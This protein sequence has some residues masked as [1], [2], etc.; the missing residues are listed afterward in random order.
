[1]IARERL[2]SDFCEGTCMVTNHVHELA[3][4]L[5][6]LPFPPEFKSLAGK[7]GNWEEGKIGR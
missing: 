4:H 3:D 1:M 5:E 7:M 6:V 2:T